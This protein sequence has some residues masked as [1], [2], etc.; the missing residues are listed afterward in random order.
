MALLLKVSA[1]GPP[2]GTYSAK[3]MGFESTTHEQ[4]GAGLKWTWEIVGGALAGQKASRTTGVSPT[5]RNGAGKLVA[6]LV[7]RA[8]APGEDVNLD[9]CV[10]KNYLIVVAEA[11][12]GGTRVETVLIAPAF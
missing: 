4:Y 5:P 12:G 11:K 2:P 3:F 8:I 10:G 1:G 9:S 7:G 6:G